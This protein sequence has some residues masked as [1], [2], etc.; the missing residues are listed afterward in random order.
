MDKDHGSRHELLRIVKTIVKKDQTFGKL[1]SY[2]VKTAFMHYITNT[3]ESWTGDTS[4]EEHFLGFLETLQN[5]LTSGNLPQ[6]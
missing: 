5:F 2:H 1:K 4:L 6:Y 3:L